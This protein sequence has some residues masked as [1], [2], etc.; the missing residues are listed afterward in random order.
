MGQAA[1]LQSGNGTLG[2]A[3]GWISQMLAL[4]AG[5]Y[6]LHFSMEG[7]LVYGANGV[8]VFLNGVQI[9]GTLFPDN[10]GSFND[11]SVNLGNLAAGSYTISFAGDDPTGADLTTFIDNIRI[12]SGVPD[13]GGTFLLMLCSGAALSIMGRLASRQSEK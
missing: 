12:V 3:G 5:S 13:S 10:L 7:R 4:P 8:D 2:G 9:G 11:V 6:N 1:F